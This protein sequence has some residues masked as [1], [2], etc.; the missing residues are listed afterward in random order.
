MY[1]DFERKI[2]LVSVFKFKIFHFLFKNFLKIYLDFRL[3]RFKRN[4]VKRKW[5]ILKDDES[6]EK[7]N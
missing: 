7:V 5:V 3:F 1:F 4:F 2:L 6:R